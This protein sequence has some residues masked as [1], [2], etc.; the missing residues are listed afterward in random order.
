MR[1]ETNSFQVLGEDHVNDSSQ[2][3]SNT[4]TI[5]FPLVSHKHYLS[6]FTVAEVNCQ[7]VIELIVTS[8]SETVA[9]IDDI[10]KCRQAI[11]LGCEWASSGGTRRSIGS[12]TGG[13]P[14][15]TIVHGKVKPGKKQSTQKSRIW[16]KVAYMMSSVSHSIWH[17]LWE[18]QLAAV[19]TVAKP[20]I[21]TT[22]ETMNL[23]MV[24]CMFRHCSI[25]SRAEHY[26]WRSGSEA[27]LSRG[28]IRLRMQNLSI[29]K[30]L[31]TF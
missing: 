19:A 23:D 16:E 11:G 13:F 4:N 24:N 8:I 31:Y 17:P 9:L 21:A 27:H 26:M 22:L 6:N 10:V 3:R 15:F 12:E 20:A 30:S 25:L 2:S 29:S 28:N 18:E 5:Y 14:V 7:G 1:V